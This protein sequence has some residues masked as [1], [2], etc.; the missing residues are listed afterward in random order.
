[1]R[2]FRSLL[3]AKS[4]IL[5]S[6]IT[7]RLQHQ[8]VASALGTTPAEGEYGDKGSGKHER[9]VRPDGL[10]V[11]LLKLGQQLDR[12]ILMELHRLITLILFEVKLLLNT[13][14]Y[15]NIT[16]LDKRTTRPSAESC[17]HSSRVIR[18]FLKARQEISQWLL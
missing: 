6:D 14:K 15:A 13:W 18:C 4:D 2:F 11:K 16:V 9:A 5:H 10:P 3:N 1:M 12:A 8:H 7:K 17:L